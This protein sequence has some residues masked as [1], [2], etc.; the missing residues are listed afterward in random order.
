MRELFI[1]YRVHTGRRGDALAA[2]TAMQAQ[3]CAR[4]PQLVA[5]L[6]QRDG[7]P[8]E[9]HTWM[10]TYRTDPLLDTL[11]ISAALQAEIAASAFALQEFIDGARHTE[12]FQPCAS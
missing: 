5:R 11:G 9:P 8:A 10:E 1:Y 2:V 3:L 6:L 12:V 7:A 4:H